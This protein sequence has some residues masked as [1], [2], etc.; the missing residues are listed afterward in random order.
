M[1]SSRV[2]AKV[3]GVALVVSAA[4][5]VASGVRAAMASNVADQGN[6][7]GTLSQQEFPKNA[8]GLSYGSLADARTPSD[9]PDLI[10]VVDRAGRF[11]YVYATDLSEPEPTSPTEAESRSLGARTIP[12]YESDGVTRI[13]VFIVRE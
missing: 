9:A 8:R 3:A 13:G 6:M 2:T 1:K 4:L 7:T 11:G 5:G 12:M 10:F